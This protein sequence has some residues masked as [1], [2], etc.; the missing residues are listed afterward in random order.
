[1]IQAE[2]VGSEKKLIN[3]WLII[4]TTLYL[5]QLKFINTSN[6]GKKQLNTGRK[7]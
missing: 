2:G 3:I 1:M 7:L 6:Y 5:Y 4:L